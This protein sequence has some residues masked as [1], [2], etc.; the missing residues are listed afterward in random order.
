MRFI[1]P[2][3]ETRRIEGD[4]T[5][6]KNIAKSLE[7]PVPSGSEVKDI[8]DL[9]KAIETLGLPLLLKNSL[10]G[11][12]DRRS[13]SFEEEMKIVSTSKRIYSVKE[14]SGLRGLSR[15]WR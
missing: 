4:K 8:K 13:I 5:A 11:G 10:G 9:K 14:L 2:A 1:G 15:K 12:R 6:S 3:P 7:I